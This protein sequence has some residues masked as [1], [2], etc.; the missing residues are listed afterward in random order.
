MLSTLR[1][2]PGR[3]VLAVL[4]LVSPALS[5]SKS[6]P[7][8]SGVWKLD[9]DLTTARYVKDDTLVVQQT[10]A[11]VK[12]IYHSG[13]RVTGTDVFVTDGKEQDRYTTRIERAYYRARWK[14]DKLV[15][16]TQHVLDALGY[17]TYKETDSWVL[18]KDGKTLTE[19]LSD[20][21]VAVYYWQAPAPKDPWEVTKEFH[22]VAVYSQDPGPVPDAE[23]QI[24]LSGTIKSS[25]LGTGTFRLCL[26]RESDPPGAARA[27]CRPLRGTLGITKGDGLSSFVL[28]VS[29]QF[30]P[31]ERNFL[32]SY[33]VDANRI[34]G[35]FNNRLTGGSGTVQFSESTETV[36]LYGVLLYE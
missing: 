36:V 27:D 16:V 12:F 5:V 10:K 20:G 3:A 35:E 31:G 30:C 17:Q 23:C 7:N 6:P 21:N 33:E 19:K 34:S 29:G 4:L 15:V 13:D 2:V 18:D 25:L 1:W 8:L 32:G 24:D 22:A 9:R 26:A 14:A 28:K 11:R